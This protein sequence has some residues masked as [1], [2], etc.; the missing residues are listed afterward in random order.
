MRRRPSPAT[1][2]SPW[3]PTEGC[4]S[5]TGSTDTTL[6]AS[7][8]SSLSLLELCRPSYTVISSIC[9]LPRVGWFLVNNSQPSFSSVLSLS[10]KCFSIHLY[11]KISV[12]REM[13]ADKTVCAFWNNEYAC[14]QI[15]SL[16]CK[17]YLFTQNDMLSSS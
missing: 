10:S 3:A 1:T 7:L 16:L 8:T 2:C 11:T 17:Q 15:L 4:T 9:I 14:P 6:K 13:D 12:R 5:W